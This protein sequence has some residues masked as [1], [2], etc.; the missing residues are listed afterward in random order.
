MD[1][2]EILS[3]SGSIVV[4]MRI[5][6]LLPGYPWKPIGG[7]RV[8]Y[9]YANRLVAK[10]HEVAIVHPRHLGKVSPPPPTASLYRRL[11][12]EVSKLRV[13]VFRPSLHWQ[14]VDGRV[15]MLYVSDL[16][17]SKVPE[18]DTVFAT[19]WPTAEYVA[20]YPASKGRKFYLV[21]DFEPWSGPKDRLEA[22]WR[23]PFQKVTVSRWLYDQVCKVEG[24]HQNTVNIPNG[25]DHKRF[26][27][28]AD[29]GSRPKRATM[30]YGYASYKAPEDGVSA[31]EIAKQQHPDMGVTVFGQL[32]QKPRNIPSWA[33]YQG[34]VSERSLIAIYNSSSIFVCSSMA[35]GFALPPAEAMACGCAV[36]STD[37]GGVREFAE[38]EVTAL[39]SPPRDPE[40]LAHNI[41]R[42]LKDDGLRQRLARSGHERIQ[43]FSWE[44]STDRL[45][46]LIR[47][48]LRGSHA[49]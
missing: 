36:V 37:C 47:G 33:S 16:H 35:E 14:P 31:L 38:H 15:H 17:A 12:R 22:T 46:D 25:V 1:H 34:N 7:F 28:T 42:L 32:D 3:A 43:G 13:L 10:G 30:F 23:Q 18:G 39:L 11:R 40:A 26:R 6:F 49:E 48:C 24:T 2:P 29:I 44:R 4:P 41:L 21:Q 20:E 5:T 19:W 27:L 45:E 8:V 9:E